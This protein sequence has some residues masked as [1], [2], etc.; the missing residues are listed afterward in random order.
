MSFINNSPNKFKLNKWG[1][2]KS[3]DSSQKILLIK[4]QVSPVT[5]TVAEPKLIFVG[6]S[7]SGIK[8]KLSHEK[9]RGQASKD[10]HT[11]QGGSLAL[12]RTA[13][14]TCT[15]RFWDSF[16]TSGVYEG[17]IENDMSRNYFAC[18]LN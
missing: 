15:S 4:Y 6:V 10:L 17:Y 13:M 3:G 1:H 12:V 11:T 14:S 16:G 18:L 8:I 9:A 5:S 2:Y 7:T